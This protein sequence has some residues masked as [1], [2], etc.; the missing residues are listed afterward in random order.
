MAQS[1]IQHRKEVKVEM[2]HGSGEVKEV[3]SHGPGEWRNITTR[4]EMRNYRVD[5][6]AVPMLTGINPPKTEHSLIDVRV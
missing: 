4:G 6:P 5:P 3:T 2:S 1:Q